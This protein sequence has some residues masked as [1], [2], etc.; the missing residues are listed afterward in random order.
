MAAPKKPKICLSVL[1]FLMSLNVGL[2]GQ[3]QLTGVILENDDVPLEFANVL[4]QDHTDSSLVVGTMTESDGTFLIEDVADGN[5]FLTFSMVGFQTKTISSIELY[6][7]TIFQVPKTILS[8]GVELAEVEVVARK[9]LYEQKIDRLVVNVENSIVS[10][11][12]TALDILE[13][14]PGVIVNRQN[15]AISLVGKEGVVVMMNGKISYMPV[16]AVVQLLAGMSSDQIVSIELITTPPANYDA[17]GNAGFIN[18]V[19]KKRSDIGLNGSYSFTGGYGKGGVTNDQINFNYRKNKVNVFGSYSYLWE[20][21]NQFFSNDRTL[22]FD[23]TTFTNANRSD[24]DPI[25][26]NHNVRL[27]L[28]LELSERTII[29]LLVGGYDNKWTMDAINQNIQSI[30]GEIDEQVT[31]NLVERNQWAHQNANIN[32]KHDFNDESSMSMDFDYLKYRDEN[33]TE[34]V[35]DYFDPSG[36]FDRQELTLSDKVTPIEILVGKIDFT[37][38]VSEKIGL[39]F[40]VKVTDSRFENGVRVETN[41]G[42]GWEADPTLTN[43]SNLNEMILAGYT[44]LDIQISDQTSFKGGLRYEHT[45]SRLDIDTE[46]RV[47][48]RQFGALFPSLFLSHQMNDNQSLGLSF[49]RRITRPTFNDMAPFIIFMDPNTFFSGNAG[50]Q[51]ALSNSAKIDYRFKSAVLSLQYSVEDSTIA[52]FQERVVNE[53]NKS[54]LEPVN[55]NQTKTFSATLGFPLNITNWWDIRLNFIYVN[56]SVEA[57]YFG[58]PTSNSQSQFQTNG[59]FSF[60]LPNDFSVELAGNYFGPS[61]FGGFAKMSSTYIVNF[62]IQKKISDRA[63]TIRFNVSDIFDSYRWGVTTEIEGRDFTSFNTFDFSQRTFSL[64]YSRNFGNQKLKSARQR[65]TGSEEE[66]RRVN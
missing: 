58:T 2:I 34:Y 56:N 63:G 32:L 4:L 23:G 55:L 59:A 42:N 66:R 19:L 25:Q 38:K 40:G 43:V 61:L 15:N 53:T 6:G 18:I 45:D 33:P 35:I 10:S 8:T 17:E 51:P 44:A 52:R 46:G 26:R 57:N 49:S 47:V 31:L 16:D 7:Q 27:G 24:R 41:N 50:I 60:T 12:S 29:G 22:A 48:D 37:Q 11:G 13:R 5:Y 54:F 20:N 1:L 65:G 30:N 3:N 62:G 36:A 21:Q 64:T 14:S 39:E 28:D 9:P